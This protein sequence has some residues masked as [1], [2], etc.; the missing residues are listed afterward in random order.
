MGCVKMA[1]Q[2]F[3]ASGL[4]STSLRRE[5]SWLAYCAEELHTSLP[6]LHRLGFVLDASQVHLEG[7][8]FLTA[9]RKL[10]L[11]GKRKHD[12]LR[13]IIKISSRQDGIREIEQER[14]VRMLLDEIGFKSLGVFCPPEIAFE[15]RDGCA[16]SV[17]S[18]IEQDL[19]FNDRPLDEQFTMAIR[20]LEAQSRVP[21]NAYPAAAAIRSTLGVDTWAKYLASFMGYCK[22]ARSCCPTQHRMLAV[23]EEASELFEKGTTIV[24]QYGEFLTHTDFVPHNFRISD[25]KFFLL[26]L[27]SI[28]VGNKHESWARFVNNT[29][30]CNRDLEKALVHRV[31]ATGGDAAYTNLR[32][33]R[34]Y[35]AMFLLQFFAHS[36]GVTT[37]NLYL[38]CAKRVTFWT[39][40]L[41][42]ILT[43]VPLTDEVVA[44]FIHERDALRS[45]D[46]YRRRRVM[47]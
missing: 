34:I 7:E 47:Q 10:V 21:L 12:G 15:K 2:F 17:V 30:F 11:T 46:E 42:A 27:A 33:M 26:D 41:K 38:L 31:R 4:V 6:L 20:G 25:G 8:R 44:A 5:R 43:D 19:P 29:L 22:V 13:V 24:A 35:K 40:V 23:I 32:L 16:V 45:A 3:S 36:L 14:L 28:R 18:Y 9:V 37:G 1:E 39:E